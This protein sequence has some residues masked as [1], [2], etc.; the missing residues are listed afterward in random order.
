MNIQSQVLSAA[1]GLFLYGICLFAT[2]PLLAQ[3]LLIVRAGDQT[4]QSRLVVDVP[5]G[6]T[7]SV[8]KD[9]RQVTLQF[10]DP[11]ITFETSAIFPRREASRV[12]RA[13]QTAS[14]TQTALAFSLNCDCSADVFALGPRKI[15]IDVRD[16][17]PATADANP[18]T[19]AQTEPLPSPLDTSEASP[20]TRDP[21]SPAVNFADLVPD[22]PSG[23]PV[24][25]AP[26]AAEPVDTTPELPEQTDSPATSPTSDEATDAAEIKA[27]RDRLLEKLARA[28]DQGLLEFRDPD[29]DHSA[30]DEKPD[31]NAPDDPE[32]AAYPASEDHAA[33]DRATVDTPTKPLADTPP[34]PPLTARTARDRDLADLQSRMPE[35]PIKKSCIKDEKLD[36]ASWSSSDPVA[37]QIAKLRRE[38]VGEFDRPDPD[39]VIKLAK[40]Y[41][42]YGFGAEARAL[43][44]S[45]G[46]PGGT[47]ALLH[48]LARVLEG[49]DA[50]PRGPLIAAADC[51]GRAALWST[52]AGGAE[53]AKTASIADIQASFD[54]L[55]IIIRR[56]IGPTLVV[57]LIEAGRQD[58]AGDI[59]RRIARAPGDHGSAYHYAR[60]RHLDAEGQHAAAEAIYRALIN[61]NRANAPE[62]MIA[63]VDSRLARGKLPPADLTEDI[64]AM[65]YQ[66]RGTPE[67]AALKLAEIRARAGA[68]DL[69]KALALLAQALIDDR[70]N[71]PILRDAAKVILTTADAERT[72]A[73]RY[74][75]AILG[76]PQLLTP[77][78]TS[79]PARLAIS[80]QMRGIG[81][82][83]VALDILEPAIAR[84]DRDIRIEAA[85]AKLALEDPD[86][87]FP[88]LEPF[89]GSDVQLLRAE[90]YSDAG[91]YTDAMATLEGLNQPALS[92][93]LAWRAG[94]WDQAL[95]ETNASLQAMAI[96]M[97]GT[98]PELVIG[99]Q[100]KPTPNPTGPEIPPDYTPAQA[101]VAPLRFE[102]EISLGRAGDLLSV[103]R[104]TR[105]LIKE[106]LRD[107]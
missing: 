27:A 25:V 37:D 28:A 49:T 63:L 54:E 57:G 58:E 10:D 65:A 26:A 82:S 3:T 94:V 56:L 105:S 107:G 69:P 99:P 89:E 9:P 16:P 43:I 48:D 67:A 13:V 17:A 19:P 51:P 87:V 5:S 30:I 81:L 91:A 72:G 15:V 22:T 103:S 84:A 4:A 32:T 68:D 85:R 41:I 74:A 45:L 29:P 39:A 44:D 101:F 14:A 33:N 38:L 64:A 18:Q 100:P 47:F 60:A 20:T 70:A 79:D 35:K 86:A 73:M 106:M 8:K 36:L 31:V 92:A 95:Q 88:L 75:E 55:P 53:L 62:A 90:A 83:N 59:L 52:V 46:R 104:G 42:H 76:Y 21:A 34:A 80:R 102:E 12:I 50:S 23:R 2:S 98:D 6:L 61:D 11:D 24:P 93:R 71:S 1:Q 66:L 7:W 78:E 77:D 96:Y 40:L 97:A